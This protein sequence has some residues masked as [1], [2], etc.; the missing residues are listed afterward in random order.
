MLGSEPVAV[1]RLIRLIGLP[2]AAE[3]HMK[4]IKPEER[5]VLENYSAGINKVVE[6]IVVYPTEFQITWNSFE[7]W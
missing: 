4:H 7:P 5:V 2:R 3:E 6:N 1:D